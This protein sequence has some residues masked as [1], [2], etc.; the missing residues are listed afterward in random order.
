M[1]KIPGT[2]SSFVLRYTINREPEHLTHT[3]WISLGTDFSFLSSNT[4]DTH[5]TS[6]TVWPKNNKIFFHNW[7]SPV[8]ITQLSS[9]SRKK[10]YRLINFFSRVLIYVE[11]YTYSGNQ[12]E[13]PVFLLEQFVYFG[14]HKIPSFLITTRQTNTFH[15]LL[16][17][18]SDNMYFKWSVRC[19]YSDK[20]HLFHTWS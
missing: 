16:N 6:A 17:I 5:P 8:A 10:Y 1:G 12:L 18:Q 4:C 3:L 11:C 9:A 14:I 15:F 2:D 19:I 7:D 13:A 20:I